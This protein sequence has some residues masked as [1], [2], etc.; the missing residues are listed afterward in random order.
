MNYKKKWWKNNWKKNIKLK[1]IL[2]KIKQQQQ[3]QKKNYIIYDI[4]NDLEKKK[5]FVDNRK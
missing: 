3:Q 4:M 5:L 2:N 1:L